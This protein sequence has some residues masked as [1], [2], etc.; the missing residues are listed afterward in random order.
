MFRSSKYHKHICQNCFT[1][2]VDHNKFV[3]CGSCY[4]NE[5]KKEI[6]LKKLLERK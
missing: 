1:N 3:L 5:N 4:E 2:N 6:K